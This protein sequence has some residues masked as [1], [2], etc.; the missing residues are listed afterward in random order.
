VRVALVTLLLVLT[1]AGAG[2]GGGGQPLAVRNGMTAEQVRVA[3]GRPGTVGPFLRREHGRCW[4][5]NRT[6]TGKPIAVKVC[7]SHGLVAGIDWSYTI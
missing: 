4:F 2:C 1:L 3:A 6:P 7:F 5:Y